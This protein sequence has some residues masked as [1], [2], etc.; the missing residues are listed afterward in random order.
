MRSIKTMVFAALANF[1]MAGPFGVRGQ[2]AIRRGGT[3]LDSADKRS[4]A[5]GTD[6]MIIV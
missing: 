2:R 4:A 6:D 3:A 5:A 1:N